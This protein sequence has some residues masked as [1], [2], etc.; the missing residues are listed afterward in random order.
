VSRSGRSRNKPRRQA[1]E[2]GLQILEYGREL[3]ASREHFTRGV[4]ARDRHSHPVYVGDSRAVRFCAGGALLR[5]ELEIF[6]SRQPTIDEDVTV[7]PQRLQ[8]AFDQLGDDLVHSQAHKVGLVVVDL[9]LL[10]KAIASELRLAAQSTKLLPP[11]ENALYL[12]FAAAVI[13]F[14]DEKRV[15]HAAILASYDRTIARTLLELA[16]TPRKGRR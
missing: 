13:Q 15:S 10:N 5:A 9:A 6:G 11:L 3:I 7:K 4:W 16:P 12:P 2:Q 8:Y 1:R 14:G